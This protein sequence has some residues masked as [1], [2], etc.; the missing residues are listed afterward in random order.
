[1]I[2]GIDGFQHD[3]CEAALVFDEPWIKAI[4]TLLMNEK[5]RVDFGGQSV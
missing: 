5:S 1:M 3:S 2:V 4:D